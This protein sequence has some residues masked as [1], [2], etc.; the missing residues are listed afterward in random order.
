MKTGP[1]DGRGATAGTWLSQMRNRINYQHEF[2]V[3]FPFG[4]SQSEVSY[5]GDLGKTYFAHPLDD[6]FYKA[7]SGVISDL[8]ERIPCF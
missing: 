3:W 4:A 5:V 6:E 7:N 8:T 2:G 1:Y